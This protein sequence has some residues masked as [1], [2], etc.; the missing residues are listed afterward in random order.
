M[1]QALESTLSANGPT[2]QTQRY[3]EESLYRHAP[4]VGNGISAMP[5]MHIGVASVYVLAAQGTKWFAPAM[6]LWLLMF[7]G[8]AY[9]G[10]H[11]WVD[12]VVAAI[13][14]WACWE[15]AERYYCRV[16]VCHR[17]LIA[18]TV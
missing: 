8:S 15:A 16:S 11:Y 3:L 13:V 1:R 9:F 14:A 17:S 5:S 4:A 7:L 2:F 18:E 12:G 6:L 10:Y